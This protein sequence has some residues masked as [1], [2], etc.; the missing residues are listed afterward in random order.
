MIGD[1]NR[2]WQPK[3]RAIRDSNGKLLVNTTDII[4]RWTT[5]CEEDES[6]LERIVHLLHKEAMRYGLMMNTDKTKTMV[7]GD[8]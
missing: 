5:Y 4:Q 2:K 1:I 3:P 6:K 8:R 7:F